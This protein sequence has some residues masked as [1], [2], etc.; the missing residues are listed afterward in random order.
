MKIDRWKDAEWKLSDRGEPLG[1]V[2]EFNGVYWVYIDG[3]DGEPHGYRRLVDPIRS[4]QPPKPR[5]QRIVYF[6]GA[7]TRRRE[8]ES[9]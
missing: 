4:L 3:D 9:E 7:L 1:F 2:R 6:R 8:D 5:R